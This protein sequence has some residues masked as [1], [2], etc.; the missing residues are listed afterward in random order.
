MKPVVQQLH[1]TGRTLIRA[2][3]PIT[4]FIKS[5][6]AV[7]APPDF[8]ECHPVEESLLNSGLIDTP[9]CVDN[10][11]LDYAPLLRTGI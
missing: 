6:G 3:P 2:F 4:S 10:T 5:Q 7:W 8:L 9:E 11:G 1:V